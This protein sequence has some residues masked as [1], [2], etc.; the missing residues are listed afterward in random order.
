[1]HMTELHRASGAP[2][3]VVANE[4]T[5][6]CIIAASRRTPE[7]FEELFGRY[8]PALHEFC[9]ARAGAAGED[10]AAETF[11]VAFDKR[12]CYDL[13][14][15]DARPWLYGIATRLLQHH[16]RHGRRQAAAI[17]RSGRLLTHP[18]GAGAASDLERRL[19]GPDVAAAVHGLTDG[20]RDALLLWAWADLQ[21][22]EIAQALDVPVGTVRSRLSRARQRVRDHLQERNQDDHQ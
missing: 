21:Y 7:A 15:P 22:S 12:G 16:F 13:G 18:E 19:L 6:A 1:M 3:L 5:D 9:C 10:V 20:E 17:E 2:L 8:W 14:Y 11:R 4:R